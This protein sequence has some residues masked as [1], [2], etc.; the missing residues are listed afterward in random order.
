MPE[1]I[2][3][4]RPGY[5]LEEAM[6]RTNKENAIIVRYESGLR[7]EYIEWNPLT[8]HIY[9]PKV[10][11]RYYRNKT[12]VMRAGEEVIEKEVPADMLT[13]GMNPFIQII[14]KVVHRGGITS[15]EDIIRSLLNEERVFPASEKHSLRIIEGILEYM[16][17]NEYYLL[18]HGEKLKVGFE[19]P[20]SYHLVQY[21]RGYD[22]F[23]YQIMDLAES[24][25]MVSRD[26]VYS[27]IIEYLEWM[28]SVSKIDMYLER[29]LKSGNLKKIQKNYFQFN[30]PLESNK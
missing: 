21:K 29:L 14:Y 28:K 9:H 2:K 18:K 6:E 10:D 16:N 5:A 30:R 24:R 22:P 15:K 11:P 20:K 7:K 13:A 26:E 8:E 23:E 25:G 1:F 4:N 17:E 12:L 27:Y 19:L 3:T